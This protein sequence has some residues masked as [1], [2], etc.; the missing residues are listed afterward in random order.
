MQT[1]TEA[2]TVSSCNRGYLA[3]FTDGIHKNRPDVR[4][5][6]T[7]AEALT[8]GREANQKWMLLLIKI[9]MCW[10]GKELAEILWCINDP[11]PGAHILGTLRRWDLG[12]QGLW[13][14]QRRQS[15]LG[16]NRRQV[17]RVQGGGL[18]PEAAANS[19]TRKMHPP[20]CKIKYARVFGGKS[21]GTNISPYSV[22]RKWS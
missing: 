17:P 11:A 19:V 14:L 12:E 2:E 16:R 18:C 9:K 4:K 7:S 3:W 8:E 10:T 20:F 6:V 13:I 1:C 15:C 5:N 22:L 21:C